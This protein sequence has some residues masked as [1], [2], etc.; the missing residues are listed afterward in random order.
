MFR[1]SP[2]LENGKQRID[3]LDG[4]AQ[5]VCRGG[6]AARRRRRESH[7][8]E[9]VVLKAAGERQVE[10]TNWFF[11]EQSVF[12]GW[13][14]ADNFNRLAALDLATAALGSVGRSAFTDGKLN[15]VSE[16]VTVRPQFFRKDFVDDGKG[17]S[18]RLGGFGGSKSAAPQQR[19]SDCRKI[20]RADAVPERS[21]GSSFSRG[22]WLVIGSGRN[23]GT[24]NRSS[25]R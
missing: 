1:K 8:K 12:A 16:R 5:Q 22:G 7:K 4:P 9:D 2:Q 11:F 17:R 25:H 23:A 21:E 14:N 10:R 15:L 18:S 13:Y 20:I 19:Q 3:A 6:F 24:E